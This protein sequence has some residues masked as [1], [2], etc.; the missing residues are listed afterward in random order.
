[1]S[2]FKNVEHKIL[3]LENVFKNFETT[4][5]EFNNEHGFAN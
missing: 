5:N 4:L 2:K 3:E 1:M